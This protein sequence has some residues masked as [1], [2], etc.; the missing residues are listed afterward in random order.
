MA[1]LESNS[2]V[3]QTSSGA[4][5]HDQVLLV[6][7]ILNEIEG[8]LFEFENVVVVISIFILKKFWKIK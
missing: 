7:A 3:L 5:K 4:N 2:S 8:K 6:N 1:V